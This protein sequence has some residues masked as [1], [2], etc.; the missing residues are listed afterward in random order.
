M[1]APR[2]VK[3]VM[4]FRLSSTV[5]GGI[6]QLSKAEPPLVVNMIIKLSFMNVK[7]AK[8]RN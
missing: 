4:M 1:E 6:G 5:S 8:V 2:E 3:A 7:K